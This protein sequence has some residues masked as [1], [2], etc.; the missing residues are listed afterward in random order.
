MPQ[1]KD[2]IVVYQRIGTIRRGYARGLKEEVYPVR[3]C[4]HWLTA[5]STASVIL[6]TKRRRFL[7]LCESCLEQFKVVIESINKE[8]LE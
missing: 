7:C 4:W 1:N 8:K 2:L 5:Q 6:E 3:S